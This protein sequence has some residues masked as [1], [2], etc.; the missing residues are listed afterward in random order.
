MGAP[1]DSE[2][3]LHLGAS[4]PF[5]CR[6]MLVIYIPLLSLRMLTILS[7]H[8]FWHWMQLGGCSTNP[9]ARPALYLL[10]QWAHT[11]PAGRTPLLLLHIR[12]PES[13]DRDPSLPC[14][15]GGGSSLWMQRMRQKYGVDDRQVQCN[16]E[17]V[18]RVAALS[19]D[20]PAGGSP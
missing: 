18:R 15:A 16:S 2:L 5:S 17:A 6:C 11:A 3:H 13:R 12:A 20:L 14:G 9:S 19:S 10:K 4:R 8:C 7:L 1:T